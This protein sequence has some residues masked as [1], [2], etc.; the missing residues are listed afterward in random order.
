VAQEANRSLG[1]YVHIPFCAS[2]CAY[3]TF[4]SFPGLERLHVRYVRALCQDIR[5]FVEDSEPLTVDTVYLGG[6]TPTVLEPPLI[7]LLLD[8]CRSA[9]DVIHDAEITVEVNPGTAG[10]E[11]LSLMLELGV[12]RISLGVQSLLD[13]E[14]QLLGRRHSAGD[15]LAAFG[16]ARQAGFS[17]INIDLI[18]GLPGQQV[19]DWSR[20]L[21]RAAGLAPEHFSLYSL[22]LEDDTPLAQRI[23]LG[24]LPPLDE[25]SAAKM[26]T[27]AEER[28]D[29][30]GYEHY[31][32]SNW[33]IAASD[34]GPR[35][36]A[37]L[38]RHNMKYWQRQPYLGFGAGAH[39]FYDNQRWWSLS[40]PQAYCEAVERSAGPTEH[41]EIVG[42]VESMAETMILGLRL[43]RG[44]S[45]A[46]FQTRHACDLRVAY[47]AQ[48]QEM[49][50]AGLLAVGSEGIT[51]TSKGRLLG[52]QVFVRFWRTDSV[53]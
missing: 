15:A 18:Y 31:E 3:C 45:F 28:L 23:S 26:Y 46:E 30:A 12:N 40:D 6:G 19:G 38:C 43:S 1:I 36:A 21:T 20:T 10:L 32:L 52:N 27:L 50:Q 51:L 33:A 5:R 29:Q 37:R 34:R 42:P 4:N 47:A 49:Q 14:L 17:N 41:C 7:Q 25:D 13:H 11:K 35:R 2:K 9:F 39:S 22:S 16:L 44:V 24:L 48:M 53:D 8:T